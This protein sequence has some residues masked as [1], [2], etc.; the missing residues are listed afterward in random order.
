[1]SAIDDFKKS[2]KEVLDEMAINSGHREF[3]NCSSVQKGKLF[4]QYFLDKYFQL[5]YPDVDQEILEA[6]IIDG[7]N[8]LGIDFIYDDEA[9]I[10]IIQSK[11]GKNQVSREV[12][13]DLKNVPYRIRDLEYIKAS[14]NSK[15]S[16]RIKEIKNNF[17]F[18]RGIGD[19]GEFS[20]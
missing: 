6:C 1:M 11:Y 14:A 9:T 3:N 20:S 12:M 16:E 15:L 2:L 13:A 4:L 19:G 8:D 5:E 18:R 7:S 10:L 17:L